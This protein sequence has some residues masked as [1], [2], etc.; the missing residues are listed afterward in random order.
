MSDP[1]DPVLLCAS[2][3]FLLLICALSLIPTQ[4]T[5][6]APQPELDHEWISV[7]ELKRQFLTSTETVARQRYVD[8]LARFVALHP[9]HQRARQVYE[10]TELAFARDLCSRGLYANALPY[11]EHAAARS[12]RNRAIRAELTIA[13]E[14]LSI[15][16]EKFSALRPGMKAAEVVALL[17]QPPPGWAKSTRK[18]QSVEE[19]WYYRRPDGGV[20]SVFFHNGKLLT[21]EYW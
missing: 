20:A 18:R 7:L 2:M 11:Y 4:C 3:R 17:G 1:P 6:R 15:S 12:P 9:E 19:S 14:H 5:S 21:A 10:E 13:R 16:K 8:A